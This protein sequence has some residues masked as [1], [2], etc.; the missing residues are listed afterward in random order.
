MDSAQRSTV[1]KFVPCVGIQSARSKKQHTNAAWMNDRILSKIKRKKSAFDCY[2][3]TREG[4]DYLEYT[5][6]RNAAERNEKSC[7]EV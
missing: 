6:A 3:Q 2:K 1:D 5:K 7:Q 4:K